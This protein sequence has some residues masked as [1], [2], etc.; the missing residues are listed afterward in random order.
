M[1]ACALCGFFTARRNAKCAGKKLASHIPL[2]AAKDNSSRI[3]GARFWRWD[4]ARIF[5][6]HPRSKTLH[7]R[8]GDFRQTGHLVAGRKAGVLRKKEAH[9]WIAEAT[10]INFGQFGIQIAVGFWEDD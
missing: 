10:R 5:R 1:A 3:D 2:A 6:E 7:V 9:V 4:D 8:G